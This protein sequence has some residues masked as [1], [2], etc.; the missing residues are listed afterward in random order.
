MSEAKPTAIG[1]YSTPGGLHIHDLKCVNFNGTNCSTD[2]LSVVDATVEGGIKIGDT[3]TENIGNMCFAV[4]ND[5]TC[6]SYN[7][8]YKGV[9]V[10]SDKTGLIYL[11]EEQPR[12]PY[13]FVC[14]NGNHSAFKM[15]ANGNSTISVDSTS[16]YGALSSYYKAIWQCTL[17]NSYREDYN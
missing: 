14:Y 1:D 12:Y 6:G 7:F 2:S 8:F 16:T 9:D 15:V 10:K 5:L 13:P 4:G 11:C 3:T 17:G